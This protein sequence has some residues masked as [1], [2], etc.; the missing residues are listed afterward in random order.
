MAEKILAP[1]F[2]YFA[3][4][5]KFIEAQETKDYSKSIVVIKDTQE[6]Y[7]HEVYVGVPASLTSEIDKLSKL[8]DQLAA[9]DV[10]LNAS[11]EAEVGRAEAKEAELQSNIDK[12]YAAL[13]ET[14][15]N[16]A[17]ALKGYVPWNDGNHNRIVLPFN[18]E[19]VGAESGQIIA[20]ANNE[21]GMGKNLYDAAHPNVALAQMNKWNVQEFGSPYY[22]TNIQGKGDRP[23]WNDNE[24]IALIKD[25]QSAIEGADKFFDDVEYNKEA[26]ELQF[27]NGDTVKAKVDV[28]DFIIDGMLDD[29]SYNA[30]TH[31]LTLVVKLDEGKT[32]EVKVDLS[33][34]VDVYDGN[35]LLLTDAVEEETS[36]DEDDIEGGI[37]VDDAVKYL[38]AGIKKALSEIAT[39]KGEVEQAN[40]WQ[41]EG[42]SGE[43]L[44]KTATGFE[45]QPNTIVKK[46]EDVITEIII[47]DD[48]NEDSVLITK[49]YADATYQEKLP[50]GTEGQMLVQGADGPEWQ[51]M[52]E[53]FDDSE[54]K[55]ELS[56]KA[57]SDKVAEDIAAAK[58]EVQE[59]VEEQ[60]YLTDHQSLENY[61]TKVEVNQAID[62]AFEWEENNDEE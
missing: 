15:K 43:V 48:G 46:G 20:Q 41:K 32:K 53:E 56:K 7:A 55:E 2:A 12:V 18:K 21:E 10:Q 11:I 38:V 49:D 40:A 17:E 39:V 61:Y 3:S 37:S 1:R 36:G 24:E 22:P 26:K 57:N 6:I 47:E 9:A 19:A 42:N 28:S 58:T 16:S 25:V 5:N 14:W 4:K 59:W 44:T 50:E 30:E 52:P 51:D 33:K 31:E 54:L 62:N 45:W 34:L 13:E 23:K 29:A 27:K 60:N 35:N 8:Y